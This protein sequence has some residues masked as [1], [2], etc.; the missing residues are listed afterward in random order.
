MAK[1]YTKQQK[2]ETVELKEKYCELLEECIRQY[3]KQMQDISKL[4]GIEAAEINRKT[5]LYEQE[6]KVAKEIAEDFRNEYENVFIPEY[7]KRM[8]ECCLNFD[9]CYSFVK[10]NMRL[11]PAGHP[12]SIAIMAY[13]KENPK[14]KD[15]DKMLLFYEAIKPVYSLSS[16]K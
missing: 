6:L 14:N 12:L 10:E 8:E 3:K 1:N 2:L 5:F 13:P 15:K 16:K 4:S 11:I 7:E 9:K